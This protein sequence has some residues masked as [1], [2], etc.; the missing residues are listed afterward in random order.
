MA[1]P[2]TKVNDAAVAVYLGGIGDVAAAQSDLGV[3][4]CR[5]HARELS[6]PRS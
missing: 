6:P 4:P 5:V 1:E 3:L 2:K